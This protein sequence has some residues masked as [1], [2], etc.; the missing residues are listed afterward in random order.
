[1]GKKMVKRGVKLIIP[2]NP[3]E[4]IYFVGS[5]ER[6]KIGYSANYETR[7]NSLKSMVPFYEVDLVLKGDQ[8]ME[9]G[10][11]SLFIDYWDSFEW[12]TDR[13]FI[14]NQTIKIM[15]DYRELIFLINPKW[16]G[17]LKTDHRK[18]KMHFPMKNRRIEHVALPVNKEPINKQRA[19]VI[20]EP[21]KFEP[22]LRPEEVA[23]ILNISKSS[24]YRMAREGIIP[25]VRFMGSVRFRGDDIQ[26]C[27]EKLML[28]KFME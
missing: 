22:L 13:N 28:P 6:V 23:A 9:R 4:Y 16:E 15:K 1:M 14:I 26:N 25:S 17:L 5:L 11:H 20:S 10:F 2:D 3:R 7:L 27:R 18:K 8:Q 21:R 24:I 19:T 12:F